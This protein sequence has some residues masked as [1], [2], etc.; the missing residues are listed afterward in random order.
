MAENKRHKWAD[1]IHAYAEGYTI[2]KLHPLSSDPK[3]AFWEKIDKPMF[4]EDMQYRVKAGQDINLPLDNDLHY[5][6]ETQSWSEE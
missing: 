5:D 4:F 6:S 1:V 2:E 3:H